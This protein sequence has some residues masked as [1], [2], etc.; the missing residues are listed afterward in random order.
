MITVRSEVVDEVV[1]IRPATVRQYVEL[2]LSRHEVQDAT[3]T[4]IFATDEMVRRLKATY[5]H[6]DAYTDVLAFR[7]DENGDPNTPG[8]SLPLEGEIYI[9]PRTAEENAQDWGVALDNE[10]SRLI[11]HGC[12]HLLGYHD[13]TAAS[14]SRMQAMEDSFLDEVSPEDLLE[15]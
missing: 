5:L 11:F 7:L 15:P 8:Q 6:Q 1:H 13:D 4:V 3:V 10:L 12:L 2:V 14:R 9:S